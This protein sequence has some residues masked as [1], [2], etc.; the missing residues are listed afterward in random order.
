MA[1]QKFILNYFNQT[2]VPVF[3]GKVDL[4]ELDR[5]RHYGY[6]VLGRINTNSNGLVSVGNYISLMNDINLI[7]DYTLIIINKTLSNLPPS[8]KYSTRLSFNID[9]SSLNILNFSRVLMDVIEVHQVPPENI[10]IEVTEYTL[11]RNEI[12]YI[13]LQLLRNF[14][15]RLSIDDFGK[16]Y[17]DWGEL[18]FFDYDEVKLDRAFLHTDSLYEEKYFSDV[19]QFCKQNKI[20]LVAEGI[21]SVEDEDFVRKNGIRFAQGFLYQK[22]KTIDKIIYTV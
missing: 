9:S 20:D 8:L 6:E 10:T 13:N 3:Q 16:D 19:I 7:H 21:E 15:V 4:T 2:V 1:N 17:S 14:G 12:K 18:K 5:K 11:S 22:P